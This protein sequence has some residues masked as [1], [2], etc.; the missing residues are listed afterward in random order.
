[1]KK[2]I[3]VLL[4]IIIVVGSV[5]CSGEK[6]DNNN[7]NGELSK[8]ENNSVVESKNDIEAEAESESDAEIFI[9]LSM[10]TFAEERWVFDTETVQAYCEEKGYKLVHTVA[11]GDSNKQKDQCSTMITQGIDVLILAP[12]DGN[13]AA[14]IVEE[15]KAEGIYVIAYDRLVTGTD[16]V[17]VYVTFNS[18]NMGQINGKYIVDNLEKKFGEVKGN[19]VLLKG[20]PGDSNS[21]QYFGGAYEELEPYIKS[22]AINVIS[23]NDCIGWKPE[24]ATK[25][26]ENAMSIADAQGIKID[27]ILAPNDGTAS[28]AI[29]ALGDDIAKETIITGMDAEAAAAQRIIAGT[30]SM[31]SWGDTREMGKASVDV[32]YELFKNGKYA[33][34]TTEKGTD[35]DGNEIDVPSVLLDV[36]F[37]DKDNVD[38]LIDEGY[39]THE[40][41]YGN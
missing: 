4:A 11:D 9:G 20:D 40:A 33:T 41:I 16:L 27:A 13:A 3:V 23:E 38:L 7:T 2:I 35:A 6:T 5:A 14:A 21:P 15:A 12:N 31:T 19:V 29:A 34:T 26:V 30:Q 36:V 39:H 22:G 24:E 25:H 28:G 10:P 1:M 8:E 32:A 17:D 37:I 18:W